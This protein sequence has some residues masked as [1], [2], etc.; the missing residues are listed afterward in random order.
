MKNAIIVGETGRLTLFANASYV[1][2]NAPARRL[3]KALPGF[4]FCQPPKLSTIVSLMCCSVL[5]KDIRR[6]DKGLSILLCYSVCKTSEVVILTDSN[7]RL[8]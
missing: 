5:L 7:A 3:L 2:Y 4:G 1:P 6:I 8:L